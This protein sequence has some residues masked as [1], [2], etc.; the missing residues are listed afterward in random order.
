[1]IFSKLLL[2]LSLVP[3]VFAESVKTIKLCENSVANV[4][5]SPKGSVLDFP[6]EPEKVILGTKGAFSIEYIRN[7]LAVSPTNIASNSNLFVYLQ[8][9]RFSLS[10]SSNRSGSTVYYIKDCELNK[11]KD[12]IRGK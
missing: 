11:R 1:M 12:S 2:L 3:N 5:I 4:L 10:L 6:S 7:D 9:R 8:G